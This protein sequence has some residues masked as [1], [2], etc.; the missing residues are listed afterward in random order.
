MGRAAAVLSDPARNLAWPWRGRLAASCAL[1]GLLAGYDKSHAPDQ[2]LGAER[3]MMGIVVALFH[4]AGYIR[5]S[6]DTLHRNGAEFTR[7]H[8][9]RGAT[10][11]SRYAAQT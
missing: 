4:D 6:D 2:R 3:A 7:T 11:L 8:V 1:V 9:M 5:Q 10:F